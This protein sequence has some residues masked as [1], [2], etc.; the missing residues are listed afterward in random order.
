[1]S[2]AAWFQPPRHWLALF[3]LITLVPSSLLVWF[4]WR[5]LQQ[6]QAL[7][8]QQMHERRE[9]AADMI[10]AGVE[11]SLSASE[12]T[13]RDPAAM[14]ALAVPEGAVAVVLTPDHIEAYPKD[15]LLYYPIA[16]AYREAPARLF[17]AA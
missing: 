1:M 10:V 17:A 8:L 13:L 2:L 6:D 11:Q 3:L 4:G 15:R 7:A 12:Q 16:Q 14:Q 5:S 9:Q